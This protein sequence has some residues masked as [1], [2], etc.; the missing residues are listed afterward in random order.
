[1]RREEKIMKRGN[2]II[3]ILAS[4]FLLLAGTSAMA[5]KGGIKGKPPPKDENPPAMDYPFYFWRLGHMD[6]PH[7]SSQ[8]LGISRDGKVA[9]GS[10]VVVE[11]TKAWRMDIDWALA[12]D[13]GLPPLYNELQVQENIGG[14]AAFAASDMTVF[15]CPYDKLA[16][17][18]DWCGSLPVGTLTTGTVSYAAEWLWAYDPEA[19]DPNYLAIPDFGGGISDMVANDVSPDGTIIV[20]TGNVKTGMVGWRADTTVVDE[21]GVQPGLAQ[22]RLAVNQELPQEGLVPR[23]DL[24]EVQGPH[25]PGGLDRLRQGLALAVRKTGDV[26][27][28]IHRGKPRGHGPER[29]L[30][31]DRVLPSR[32]LRGQGHDQGERCREG[33]E[34]EPHGRPPHGQGPAADLGS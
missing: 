1:M 31:G 22:P 3:T 33:Q 4:A 19:A 34:R 5:A 2:L 12:T 25:D 18:L 32:G 9:V 8:A 15:N 16:E 7:D 6:G 27:P 13:D 23:P 14:E 11:F 10:T 21:E 17:N 20:G 28:E 26:G 30:V 29:P 24:P